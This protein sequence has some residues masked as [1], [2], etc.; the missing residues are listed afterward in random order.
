MESLPGIRANLEPPDRSNLPI[1][2]KAEELRY[3]QPAG[4]ALVRGLGDLYTAIYRKLN[5][6]KVQMEME[7][8]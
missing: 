1:K 8:G 2:S 6:G 3:A 7:M 5:G 4:L